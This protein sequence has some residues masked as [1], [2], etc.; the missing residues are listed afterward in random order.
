GNKR[1]RHPRR[2]HYTQD[3]SNALRRPASRACRAD[4]S[5]RL[6]SPQRLPLLNQTIASFAELR[7]QPAV[8]NALSR[9]GID[10][11]TPIQASA[12]P[13]LMD[14]R[15]VVGQARTG[16]GKTLAYVLP[17][18]ERLEPTA[19]GVQA[20]VLVPTRELA[21]QVGDVFSK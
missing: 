10:T 4:R 2:C 17:M 1:W 15:D 11:P 13:P 5:V 16:S 20:L 21:V 9:M 14:G 8:Y 6:I 3:S 18:V 19:R 12:I 7:L